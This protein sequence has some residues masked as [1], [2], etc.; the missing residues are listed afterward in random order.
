[1]KSVDFRNGNIVRDLFS[2][3]ENPVDVRVGSQGQIYY[4]VKAVNGQSGG[5]LFRVD[6]VGTATPLTI[7]QQPSNQTVPTGG[8]ATFSVTV[9]GGTGTPRFQWQRNGVDIASAT[10]S[11]YTLSGVTSADNGAQ[12]RVVVSDDTTSVT[13]TSATLTVTAN[14]APTATIDLPAAG[15]TYAGG[16]TIQY[17]GS[18]TDPEDGPLPP[19]AFTWEVVFHHNTHTHD[20]ITPISGSTSG[21]F[22]VPRDNETATDVFY[23]VYLTVKDSAGATTHVDRDVQP[24]LSTLTIDTSPPG[25]LVTLDGLQKA[26]PLTVTG[27][28]GI[29]R[30]LG[31]VQPQ[32]V[33]GIT[34]VFDSWSDAGA[35]TH[36]IATPV[37]DTTYTATF[38]PSTGKSALLVVGSAATPGNDNLVKNRLEAMGYVARLVD[39]DV[40]TSADADGMSLVVISSSVN[41]T[42]VGTKFRLVAVPVLSYKPYSYDDMLMTGPTAETDYG[43]IV[44]VRTVSIVASAHPLAAGG[45]RTVTLTSVNATLPWGLPPSTAD[46]VGTT[47]GKASL[48]TFSPGDQLYDGRPAPACRVAFPS[49]LAAFGNFTQEGWS[50]FDQTVDWIAAGCTG[51]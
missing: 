24:R 48:F 15:A 21:S 41:A 26:T 30:T 6:Y 22:S 44:G 47:L 27:V 29:T 19:A 16:D 5:G 42:T 43:N 35:A 50:L 36:N 31:V 17:S 32:Q 10:A 8:S 18:A 13:S 34:Y 45:A 37:D 40:A 46:V 2:G 49:S 4:L 33:G 39:D 14:Q 1:M 28:E 23:R 12:F 38:K 25:L 7:T 51:A 11:T 3:L 9:S 20:F